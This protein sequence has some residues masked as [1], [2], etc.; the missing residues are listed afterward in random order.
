MDWIENFASL[1]VKLEVE[2]AAK[3]IVTETKDNNNV[4]IHLSIILISWRCWIEDRRNLV[5][6]EIEAH[7][8]LI[9]DHPIF[10]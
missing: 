10:L 1:R 7:V 3:A 5:E 4:V 8:F 2:V 9:L 6:R